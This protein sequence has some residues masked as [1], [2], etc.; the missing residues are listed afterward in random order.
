MVDFPF[1]II[2]SKITTRNQF[3]LLDGC[4]PTHALFYLKKGRF[5]V[6][7][8]EINEEV[9]EGDC[10]ILPDYVHFKRSVVNPIEFLYIKF[11]TD[12][13]CP[14][15]FNIPYGK[16]TFKDKTRF[17]GNIA[18]LQ[19]LIA[20]DNPLSIGYR[21]HLLRD[22]LFQIY[23]ENQ[24]NIEMDEEKMSNDKIINAAVLYINENLCNK[25]L[26]QDICSAVGTNATTLNFKFRREFDIS[27]GKFILRQRMKK[28]VH[29]LLSTTYN[30]EEIALRCG[31][32]NGYYFSNV[33]KK[34]HNVSPM[35]FRKA[36]GI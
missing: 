1:V 2:E 23:F 18:A 8:D 17:L 33:F 19:E 31:F 16:V 6:E 25:I 13:N 11:A 14:Y 30:I 12:Y 9:N 5:D 10:V 28:A 3:E 35:K 22:I 21:E 7:I 29:L 20:N 4:Q 15:S 26:I 34:E 27:V 32:E 24:E 36:R